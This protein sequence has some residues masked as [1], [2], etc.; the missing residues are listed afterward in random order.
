MHYL[1]P[2]HLE[3]GKLNIFN[4]ILKEI[5]EKKFNSLSINRDHAKSW[6]SFQ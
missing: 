5:T 4:F 2:E 1:K 6:L 3:L